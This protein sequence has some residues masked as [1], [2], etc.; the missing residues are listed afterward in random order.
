MQARSKWEP[1]PTG[2]WGFAHC[3]F[4]DSWY[5]WSGGTFE[6]RLERLV[7]D[8]VESGANSFRP[9]G[10]SEARQA[11]YACDSVAASVEAGARG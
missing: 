6:D 3:A 10:M 11:E 1:P 2:L 7:G 4:Y 9:R 5:P 8:L